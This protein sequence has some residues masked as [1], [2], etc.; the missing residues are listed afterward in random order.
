[1]R[2]WHGP[3]GGGESS[4]RAKGLAHSLGSSFGAAPGCRY[5]TDDPKTSREQA[6]SW[7]GSEI[8]SGFGSPISPSPD[9]GSAV[10]APPQKKSSA[11]LK[12]LHSETLPPE[13][14]LGGWGGG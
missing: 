13:G 2:R 8:N 4:A 10:S 9:R 11:S 1:M 5:G 12:P 14:V 7:H 3:S 6:R